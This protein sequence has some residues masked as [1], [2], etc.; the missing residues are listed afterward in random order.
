VFR[1]ADGQRSVTELVDVVG[2]SVGE[3]VDEDLILITLDNLA[4]AHLIEGYESREARD[5]RHS[6]RRF[7]RRAGAVAAAATVLPVVHTIIAPAAAQQSSECE[8]P[9]PFYDENCEYYGD[10]Y[11]TDAGTERKLR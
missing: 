11:Y 7:I 9:P 6:R 8:D 10:E 5:A 1:N 2:S 4:D 3:L